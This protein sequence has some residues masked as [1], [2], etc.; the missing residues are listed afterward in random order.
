MRVCVGLRFSFRLLSI[1][2]LCLSVVSTRA[3]LASDKPFGG[4][5]VGKNWGK[6]IEA[7]KSAYE[8]IRA[9]PQI[10]NLLRSQ[11]NALM[12]DR[13][14]SGLEVET[15]RFQHYFQGIE[16]MGSQALRHESALQA[17]SSA[18]SL[19][20]FDLDVRPSLSVE[21]AVGVAQSV[22]DQRKLLAQPI[23]KIL[24]KSGEQSARLIYVIKLDG[25]GHKA[26]RNVYVDAHSGALV[27]DISHHQTI[28]PIE[29]FS[30]NEKCQMLESSTDDLGGRA[31]IRLNHRRC[32][33]VVKLGQILPGADAQALRAKQ[34]S[35]D[36]LNYYQDH[37]QRNSFDGMGSASVSVV[38]VGEKW[39]N[40]FWDSENEIMAYGDGDGKVFTNLTESLDVSGHE[41]THGVV[42]KTANLEYMDQSGALNEAYADFFGEL[43]EGQGDWVMGRS[44][45]VDPKQGA[46]GLRN[47]RNPNA[48][49][50]PWEGTDG[51][52]IKRPY[53][54][55][56]DQLF[57]FNGSCGP[58][59]DNC[60]VHLNSTL[61]SH[62][63]FLTVQSIGQAAA[64]KLFYLTLTQFLTSTSNFEAFADG[65]LKACSMIH[66]SSTCVK[67]E[68]VL[69]QVGLR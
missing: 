42:S 60:G 53:P 46:N 15:T 48:V 5:P 35:T 13:K 31:P 26:G 65:T 12:L 64:E 18:A 4:L 33:L 41:M 56:K 28:A 36:V 59:N 14:I 44:L 38:H 30:T 47:I 17:V 63:G 32:D 21:D 54:K 24:P 6:Q 19:V 55:H 43:I 27:A 11:G 1:S 50:V 61:A 45:F 58:Q 25:Q 2:L 9:I 7:M 22:T 39:V 52:E 37:H 29:V 66:D 34:N 3:S 49:S 68:Q 20:Q 8:Q 57:K 16:V 69:A 10:Q 23:L 62:A 51:A 40:A 67:V